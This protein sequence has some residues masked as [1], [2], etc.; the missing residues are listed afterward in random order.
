M[1]DATGFQRRRRA[2][3]P[4]ESNVVANEETKNL[5]H[6]EL[7]EELEETGKEP[8]LIKNEEKAEGEL[9]E[10]SNVSDDNQE[11]EQ[12]ANELTSDQVDSLSLA[13]VKEE[14]DSRNIDYVHNTGEQKLKEKLKDAIK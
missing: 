12:T 7:I 6:A 14:L 8:T 2:L 4:T 9:H 13:Q 1:S 10:D 5:D 3:P 11:N